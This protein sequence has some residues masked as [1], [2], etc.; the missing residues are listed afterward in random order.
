MTTV[1]VDLH[2]TG[3]HIIRVEIP[4]ANFDKY[5]DAA[6]IIPVNLNVHQVYNIKLTKG[7]LVKRTK[8]ITLM[9]YTLL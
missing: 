4:S 3:D 7:R 8:Y 6:S 5:M 2:N 9:R 1:P